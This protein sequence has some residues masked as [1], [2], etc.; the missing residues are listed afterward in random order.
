[1]KKWI[2]SLFI[3]LY[4]TTN[5][6]FAQTP[7][8]TAVN[9]SVKDVNG[10]I[11]RL[12]D[13]LD[14][15][16]IVLLDFFTTACGSC[17]IYAPE[18][19]QTYLNFGCNTGN[20]IVLGINYGTDNHGVLVFDSLFNA[21][22]PSVSGI[23]GRGNQI[24][25]NYTILSYPTV[26]LITPDK[27]IAQKYIWPPSAGVLDSLLSAYGGVLSPC[28]IGLK[29]E[30]L[31]VTLAVYPNPFSDALYLALETQFAEKLVLYVSDATGRRVYEQPCEQSAQGYVHRVFSM[32]NCKPGFYIIGVEI[33]G[34]L[35]IQKKVCKIAQ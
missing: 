32:G 30:K 15:G 26:I 13:Y 5:T 10:N 1:M 17:Q 35:T 24:N 25:S 23:Q 16:K 18:V 4:C 2:A 12:Y 28:T 21:I 14:E 33:P 7:L 20:V 6:I 27:L 3:I 9:F 22:Y 8:D 11:H 34:K 19:S 29:E 31:P